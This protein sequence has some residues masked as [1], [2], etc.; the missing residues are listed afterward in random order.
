MASDAAAREEIGMVPTWFGFEPQRLLRAL[1]ANSMFPYARFLVAGTENIPRE[2]PAILAPNHRSFF[3]LFA[4]VMLSRRLGRSLRVM[5]KAEL[6]AAPILGPTL[7]AMGAV[8]VDRDGSARDAFNLARTVL[9]RGE[10]L[11]VMPEGTIPRG[12]A[13]GEP[14]LQLKAGAVRLAKRCDV[15][16][17]P[18]G[19]I[20]TE[21]VW[22]R[23]SKFPRVTKVL[24]PPQVNIHVGPSVPTTAK[25]RDTVA[26]LADAISDQIALAEK[27][28]RQGSRYKERS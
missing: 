24:N 15:P 8:P 28:G 20:G 18:V 3:D 14:A 26:L 7:L 12:E 21:L 9:D 17:V 23:Q 22:P 6:C 13:F 10:L 5:T 27:M 16:L 19:M 11:V 25:T 1:C 2:G 4:L